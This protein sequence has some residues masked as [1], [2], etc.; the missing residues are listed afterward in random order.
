[1]KIDYKVKNIYKFKLN[2]EE[3][4]KIIYKIIIKNKN[5]EE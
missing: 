5:K 1:M 4:N 2:K 3:L